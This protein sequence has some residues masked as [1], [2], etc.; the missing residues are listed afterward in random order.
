M[1]GRVEGQEP[2]FHVFSVESRI[3][4]DHPLRGLKRIVD[5]ILRELSPEFAKAYS[6]IGRPSVPPERLLK[7]LLLMALYS[8]RSE[9]QLVE[10][11]DTDLL[12]RWFLDVLPEEDVF[13]ATAFTHNRPRLDEHGITAKFFDAVLQKAVHAGL[14]SDEHFS[15]D[16]SLIE[17]YASIKS[18]RPKDGTDSDHQGDQQ[19]NDDRQD[20]NSFKPRNAEV[21]FHGQKRTND[22]HASRTDPEAKLYRKGNGKEA[23]LS[24]LGHAL[25]ENRHGLVMGVTTTEANGT[26]ECAAALLMLD[27]LKKQHKITPKTLGADKGFDSGPFF[28]ELE[29]RDIEPHCA[30]VNRAEPQAKNVSQKR[31]EPVAARERMKERVE[32]IGY[33]LSQKCR[34][35]VEE[36]FGWMKTVAE[37]GRS[38]W[39]GRWKLQQQLELTAAAYNLVRMRKLLTPT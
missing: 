8:I 17:S 36:F 31:R 24:H 29:R 39:V 22:T 34:K 2:L 6:S 26:A 11:I 28:L 14:C 18:F 25:S 27:Q 9:R 19:H 33:Q 37:L 32:S 3:R 35:K 7:A 12:F 13:D 5:G 21:D 15:V 30:I 38:R 4:K 16:G 20:S 23:K 1:R 10:R